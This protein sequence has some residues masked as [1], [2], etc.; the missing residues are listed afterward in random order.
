LHNLLLHS[1]ISIW[2]LAFSNESKRLRNG[3]GFG[4]WNNF[5]SFGKH[6]DWNF[7]SAWIKHYATIHRARIGLNLRD[8]S[9][10]RDTEQTINQLDII[11]SIEKIINGRLNLNEA[12][13][14]KHQKERFDFDS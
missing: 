5:F 4:D 14:I 10:S 2:K 11:V 9:A 13:L 1:H 7:R 3:A 6:S 12:I 8:V